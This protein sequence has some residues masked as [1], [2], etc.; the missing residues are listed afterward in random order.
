MRRF[1]VGKAAIVVCLC[2][3]LCASQLLASCPA[4]KSDEA[5][6]GCEALEPAANQQEGEEPKKTA[7]TKDA[8]TTDDHP[9][10]LSDPRDRIYY[11][12]DTERFKPLMRKLIG[13]ILLDQKEI[14]TSP[15]RMD[16]HNAKWWLGFGA[17]TGVLI[18]TD[19]Q[20]INVFENSPGQVRWGTNISQIGATYTLLPLLAGFYGYGVVRDNPKARETGILGAEA[21]LDSVI[22]VEVLKVTFGR[23]RPDDTNPGKFFKGGTSFPSGHTILSWSAASLVSH[24]YKNTKIVPIVAYGLATLVSTA[25]FTAQKHYASDILAGAAMGWFIG[26][27]V[28]KTHEDHALHHHS[29]FRPEVVPII[30]PSR[31]SFGIMLAFGP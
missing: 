23:N 6:F 28:Y 29:W 10:P 2:I 11:P 31:N 5:V 30:E 9:T 13:N 16:R 24:E 4:L 22:V 19:H 1:I 3:G 20:T 27:F 21:L 12:G 8:D 15:F 7:E 14:W 26:R 25:R 18:A 17:A